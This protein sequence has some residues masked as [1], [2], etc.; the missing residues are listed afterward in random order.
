VTLRMGSEPPLW[1]ALKGVV[2]TIVVAIVTRTRFHL[3]H[4]ITLLVES[5]NRSTNQPIKQ[6]RS[7]PSLFARTMRKFLHPVL[8]RMICV[9]R[10]GSSSSFLSVLKSTEPLMLQVDKT[11][12]PAWTGEREG[13]SMEDERIQKLMAKWSWTSEL[14]AGGGDAKQG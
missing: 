6:A 10:D 14:E 9:S 7:W 3:C 8:N 5:L 1:L 11:R 12:H 2:I 4:R 13:V